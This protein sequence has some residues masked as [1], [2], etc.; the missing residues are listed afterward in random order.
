MTSGTAST[1]G[2]TL[3]IEYEGKTHDVDL[4]DI[5]IDQAL[6]IEKHIGGPML[7]WEQGMATGRAECVRV[8]GWLI[9]HGGNLEVPIASV[10]FKY[11]KLMKAFMAATEAE[12][13]AEAA[14][15][16]DGPGPT[17]AASNGRRSARVSSPSE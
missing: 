10:N 14:K 7:E 6:K 15:A 3:I 1:E 9:L 2:L 4:D 17:A 5:D 8:L 13:K 12:E 16:A 11:P